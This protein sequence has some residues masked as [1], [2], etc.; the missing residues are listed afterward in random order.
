M[1]INQLQLVKSSKMTNLT[2]IIILAKVL[3]MLEH[4]FPVFCEALY[5]PYKD[6]SRVFSVFRDNNSLIK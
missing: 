1:K 5:R 3:I 2:G 6:F 4:S